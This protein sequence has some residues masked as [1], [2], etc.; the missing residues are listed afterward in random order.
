[1]KGFTLVKTIS[2]KEFKLLGNLPSCNF[3]SSNEVISSIMDPFLLEIFLD[4]KHEKCKL[5]EV[6]SVGSNKTTS[7]DS[8]G[9]PAHSEVRISFSLLL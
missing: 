4:S 9:A 2:T 7:E 5:P 6:P 1:M 8:M 3:R